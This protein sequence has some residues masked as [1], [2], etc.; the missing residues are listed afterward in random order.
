MNHPTV[1]HKHPAKALQSIWQ[2]GNWYT[3]KTNKTYTPK[4]R[5][6]TRAKVTAQVMNAQEVSALE[7]HLDRNRKKLYGVDY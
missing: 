2:E 7:S 3:H 6:S 4:I 1:Y 5:K